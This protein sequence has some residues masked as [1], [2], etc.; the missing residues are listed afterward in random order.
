MFTAFRHSKKKE[1]ERNVNNSLLIQLFLI[2]TRDKI[3]ELKLKRAEVF[4]K[5]KSTFIKTSD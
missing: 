4:F 1:N 5:G 3:K 2:L